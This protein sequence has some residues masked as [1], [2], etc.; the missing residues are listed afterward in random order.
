MASEQTRRRF[1]GA[2][3]AIAGGGWS[4]DAARAVTVQRATALAEVDHLIWGVSDLAAGIAQLERLTGV[5]P[6][7]GG[8]HPGRGTRNGILSLGSRQ[9]IEVLAPDPQ[10]PEVETARMAVLKGL[11]AP[12]LLTWCAVAGDAEAMAR[13]IHA[14]GQVVRE[15]RDGSRQRPDGVTLRWRNVYVD[16]HDDD[17][18]PYAIAWAEGTPHPSGDAPVGGSLH[19]LRLEHPM[20]DRLNALLAAMGLAPRVEPGPRAQLIATLDTPRGEVL[21]R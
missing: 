13:R 3:L 6:S 9:Y 18:V 17:V 10:Q 1:L 4:S 11:A 15:I 7:V 12:R 21:L 8:R 2:C 20:P 16:G 14:A 5:R 19:A